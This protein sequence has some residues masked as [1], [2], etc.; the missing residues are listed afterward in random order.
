MVE[1]AAAL[2]SRRNAWDGSENDAH[3]AYIRVSPGSIQVLTRDVNRAQ[4]TEMRARAAHQVAA[5]QTDAQAAQGF[6]DWKEVA[7]QDYLHTDDLDGLPVFDPDWGSGASERQR[8]SEWSAKSRANMVRKYSTLDYHP[9]LSRPDARPAM[10]TLTYPGCDA[11]AVARDRAEGRMHRCGPSCPWWAVAPDGPSVKAHMKALR[12]RLVRAWGEN[13]D[14]AL[15]KLEFQRRGAPHLH[16]FLMIPEGRT[17]QTRPDGSVRRETFVRWLSRSWAEIVGH[18]DAE[19]QAAHRRAGTGGDYSEGL[20]AKDP[21]RLAIYFSKHSAAT[22]G[23]RKEYQHEVPEAFATV[24]RFWGFWRLEPV[25]ATVD[26]QPDQAVQAARILRRWYRAKGLTRRV[27]VWRST[28]DTSTGEVRYRKRSTV[29]RITHMRGTAGFI[30]ANDGPA[31]LSQV[32][33]AL[34]Q[35]PDPP[36]RA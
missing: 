16:L 35:M 5:E 17:T 33:R 27:Q 8:I 31:L 4:R 25:T 23:S 34:D 32:A 12:K 30:T 20:R 3:R 2:L 19:V 6:E 21:Q 7:A 10:V 36:N 15:W 11:A 22:I 29:K 1:S 14:Q 9:M 18:P 26:V 13:A 28:V 24:G